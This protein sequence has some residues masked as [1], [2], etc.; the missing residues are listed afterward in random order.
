MGGEYRSLIVFS[1]VSSHSLRSSECYQKVSIRLTFKYILCKAATISLR[2]IP[3]KNTLLGLL[4]WF[5][6]YKKFVLKIEKV[7]MTS[8]TTGKIK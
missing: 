5:Y 6:K 7:H 1:H 4:P 3:N 8:Q 2:I